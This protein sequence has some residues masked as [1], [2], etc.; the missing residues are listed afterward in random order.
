MTVWSSFGGDGRALGNKTTKLS[1]G[2]GNE[3]RK[4]KAR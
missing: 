4:V 3:R 1:I 2:E